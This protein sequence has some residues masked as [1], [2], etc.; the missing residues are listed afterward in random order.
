M[1]NRLTPE[2]ISAIG[3]YIRKNFDRKLLTEDIHAGM[4]DPSALG[5]LEESFADALSELLRD[6]GMSKTEFSDRTNISRQMLHAIIR[7]ASRPSKSTAISCAIVL[8]L[9]MDEAEALLN[10]AGYAFTRSSRSDLIVEYY[11]RN[12]IYDI[13]EI[14]EALEY[15]NLRPLFS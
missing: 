1:E 2:R 4:P 5:E 6:S 12:R 9:S 10:K 8:R 3:E 14:N 15:Y 13:F 11:I 7:D